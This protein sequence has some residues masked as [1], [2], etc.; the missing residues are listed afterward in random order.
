MYL[1]EKQVDFLEMPSAKIPISQLIEELKTK[2][3]EL[4]KEGGAEPVF[5]IEHVT[6]CI[7]GL[8][9]QKTG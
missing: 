1:N 6:S 3:Q 2:H 9:S 7:H 5:A 4:L 8:Q